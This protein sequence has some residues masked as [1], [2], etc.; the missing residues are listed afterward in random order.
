MAS[1]VATAGSASSTGPQ[2]SSSY[3]SEQRFLRVTGHGKIRAFVA[4]ALEFLD[5][6]DG[7]EILPLPARTLVLH[8]LPVQIDPR[9]I[10]NPITLPAASA[11]VTPTHVANALSTIPRLVTVAEIIKREYVK[12]LETKRSMRLKGLYQYNQVRLLEDVP[13]V[14]IAHE[15]EI[16]QAANLQETAEPE[17]DAAVKAKKKQQ[18]ER[19]RSKQII[20]ALSGKNHPR[21]TQSPYMTITLS[22]VEKTEL[23][24]SGATYQPP[25]I[26]KISRNAKQR[27]KKR[28]KKLAAAQ[29]T[30][31]AA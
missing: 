3:S 20:E 22:T 27:A 6:E 23:L 10:E 24:K 8:T 18:A 1:N 28:E 15:E 14:I 21:Q 17:S 30:E 9:H 16:S 26:R 25:T 13:G 2:T 7:Q 31:V 4:H 12:L 11:N 19:L 5:D 29:T